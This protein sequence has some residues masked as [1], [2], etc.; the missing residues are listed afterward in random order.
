MLDQPHQFRG[1]AES[2]WVPFPGLLRPAGHVP[3][4]CQDVADPGIGEGVEGSQQVVGG[5]RNAGQ[6]AYDGG[7]LGA[8]QSGGRGHRAVAGGAGSPVGDRQESRVET[9]QFRDGCLEAR[10]LLGGTGGKELEAQRSGTRRRGA[11]RQRSE[12]WGQG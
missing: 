1:V 8:P 5:L 10:L 9:A 11:A 12:T 4:D 6:V 2:I 3:A 7:V